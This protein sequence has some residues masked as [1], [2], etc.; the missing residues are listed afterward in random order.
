MPLPDDMGN[1]SSQN[2]ILLDELSYDILEMT[3]TLNDNIPKLNNNQ[4]DVF[5]AIYNSAINNEGWTPFVYGYGGT[6][7]TF[8]WTTLLYSLR[9]PGKIALA[10]ASSG[11]A[12]LLLRGGRTP[13]SRFKIPLEIYQNSMCSIKKDT[14]LAE[15]IQNTSLIVWDEASVNHKYCFE[16]LDRTLRDIMSDTRPNAENMQF[17]GITVVLGGDFCQTLLV[18]KH[19]TRQQ[20]LK[21]CILNSYL[22]NQCTLL[23]LNENMRL[24]SASLSISKREALQNFAGW[25]LRVGNGTKPFIPIPNDPNSIFIE[26][27]Q[28]LLL[29]AESRNI[30]GLISFVYDS[31]CESANNTSYL[32]DHA[33]LAPTN[34]VVSKINT[35]MI[36]QLPTSEMS[37]YSADSIGDSYPNH[38]SLEAL[39]PIEFLNKLEIPGLPD[40]VLHLKIVVPIMLL[41]NLIHQEGFVMA[42]DSLLHN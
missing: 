10:V 15:L 14:H 42:L 8:L 3:S 35:R 37:Y 13:H 11:I 6:G 12:S 38:S 32:C 22:W 17:G 36:S 20:I 16:A 24:S 39:Y 40:H 28:H 41:R 27:P 21:S 7:K 34:D 29:S 23:Q 33:I 9:S 31:G 19:A 30:D 5:H 26:I 1:A 4:K 18:I 25:L 2:R